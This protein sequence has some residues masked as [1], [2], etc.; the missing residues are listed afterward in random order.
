M[1]S[2]TGLKKEDDELP[3]G[4]PMAGKEARLGEGQGSVFTPRNRDHLLIPEPL[5]E[6]WARML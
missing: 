2:E 4:V 6:S 3:R 1:S 5:T